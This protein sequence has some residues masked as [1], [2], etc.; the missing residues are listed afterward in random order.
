MWLGVGVEFLRG[1]CAPPPSPHIRT[2]PNPPGAVTP[3]TRLFSWLRLEREHVIHVYLYAALAGLF[4]L[5]LPLGVQAVVGL[6]SGGLLLQPVVLLIGFVILGTLIHG[7][8]QVL[9]LSVVERIQQ[10]LFA[11]LAFDFGERLPILRLDQLAGVDLGELMN[12]FF[13]IKTIQKSLAKLLTDWVAAVLQVVF[14]LILLT[15]YHPYFSLFGVG[16]IGALVLVFALTAPRGLATS[17]GESKYKYRVAHW[18]EEI[19]RTAA[20][21]KFAGGSTM[22]LERLDGEVASYLKQRQAHF[23]VLVTQSM[24]FVAL[25]VIVTGAVL[26]MGSFLVIDRQIT[27]GQFVASELVIVLVLLAIEK[28]IFG[29]ADVYDVLTAVHKAADVTELPTE[30]LT[31]RVQLPVG[32]PVPIRARD[33]AFRYANG[34]RNAVEGLT[35]EIAGGSLC[36]ITGREGGGESTLLR[37]LSGIYPGYEG[38]VS[39]SG[40]SLRDI[41]ARTLRSEIAWC[42][43]HAEIFDG[44]VLENV[45][46]GRAIGAADA[47]TALAAVGLEKWVHLQDDGLETVLKAGGRYL[48]RHVALKITLARA[49][50]GRP[51]VV[52]I[53]GLLDQIEPAE[54]TEISRS[55]LLATDESTRVI[56]TDD[57]HILEMC[58]RILT[59]SDGALLSSS[60]KG[61]PSP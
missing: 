34:R 8:L 32:Q 1:P 46:V 48:A 17:L 49:I 30:S 23:R 51:R 5:T 52:F 28:I 53:D 12:R 41:E 15:F 21:F 13:E 26:I 27:L 56:A 39:Y 37:V 40:I 22:A 54:R 11:R 35:F 20:T 36:G 50:A 61:E 24:A 44:S 4:S 42:G 14:G 55:V 16:L 33:L 60:S 25:K 45:V 29:L 38:S 57:P 58:D 3:L 18:L 31:G 47:L 9:Q 2:M 59:L 6:I 19:A 7:A 10:R 43:N